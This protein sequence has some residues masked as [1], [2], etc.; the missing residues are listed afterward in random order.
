VLYFWAGGI[1]FFPHPPPLRGAPQH[2]GLLNQSRTF[3]K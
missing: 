1:S 3:K 2:E